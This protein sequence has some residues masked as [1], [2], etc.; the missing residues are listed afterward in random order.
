MPEN[1]CE[2][3]KY[4]WVRRYFEKSRPKICKEEIYCSEKHSP[5]EGQVTIKCGDFFDRDKV[6]KGREKEVRGNDS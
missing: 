4:Y 1:I 6:E 2:K 5:R 3:C